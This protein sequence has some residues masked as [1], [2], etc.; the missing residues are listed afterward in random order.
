MSCPKI[1]PDAV[2]EKLDTRRCDT[3]LPLREGE[4]SFV[5]LA[6]EGVEAFA[7]VFAEVVEG[8][9]QHVVDCLS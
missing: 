9:D 1:N 8:A 2:P 3:P 5:G 6:D 4:D 7:G